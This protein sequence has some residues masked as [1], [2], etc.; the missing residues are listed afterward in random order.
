LIGLLKNQALTMGNEKIKILMIE[1]SIDDAVLIKRKLESSPTSRFQVTPVKTLQE[2]LAHLAQEQPDLILSDLG[3]PDSHGLDTVNRILKE[4]PYI[5]LVVLSGYDD[6]SVAIKAVQAGAQD[7]LVKGRIDNLQMERSLNYSIERARLQREL[8]QHN[9]EIASV[10]ANLHKVLEKNADAILVISE[11]K[12][13]LFCNPAAASLLGHTPEELLK[14]K[15]EFEIRAGVTFE[16]EIS[17]ADKQNKTAEVTAVEIDWAGKTASLVS[18]HD[19]TE[20]KKQ[21]DMLRF[22]DTALKSIH[23]GVFTMDNEFKITRWN[24]TCELM[25]G[26]K[27]SDAIGKPAADSI[28][29]VE[30]YK[31]QTE[32]RFN[33][34]IE[35]GFNREDQLYRTPRGDIWFDVQAQEMVTDGKRYGW[36]SLASDISER[37]KQEDM[38][39]FSDIA[40]KSIHEGVFTMNND[41][42]I[43]R[44]N[45]M[46]EQIVGVKAPD[47]I[48][49]DISDPIKLIEE[50]EGQNNEHVELLVKYGFV[51]SVQKYRTPH[52]DIW[53]D[54][55]TQAM[56][57]NGERF[58]WLTMLSDITARKNTEE[59][60]KQSEEKYREVINTSSD[61][62][63]SVD[64]KMKIIL[65]NQGASKIFG[66]TEKEMIGESLLTI[67]P[68]MSHQEVV[69]GF[70]KMKKTG[71]YELDDRFLNTVGIKK[72]GTSVFIELSVTTH[73]IGDSPI[74]TAII[75][76][77]TFR[78]EAEEALK[79]SEEKY[80]ELI[81]TSNDAIVSID[82]QMQ[83]VLWNRGAEKMLGYTEKEMLGL[84]LLTIFP[85]TYQKNVAR[86][87]VQLKNTG[88]SKTINKPF[89][90]YLI[91][92]D[93]SLVPVDMSISTRK[94][95]DKIISTAIIR[96]IT[97]RK[98]AEEKM[99][100]S[101]ERYRD[102]FENAS[103]LIQS[104]NA[105]GKF[106]YVNTAWREALGYSEEEVA[107][108]SLW[109]VIFPAHVAQC[110]KTLDRVLSGET[111][112]NIETAFVAKDGKII[113]VE[114][115]V[116]P[117]RKQDKVIANRAIFH[118]IN[119]RKEAEE[120]MRQ[121]DQ[122]KS[123]F[124]SNVS[125]ELRTPLQ[126]ISGFTKLI[127]NGDVPDT[128]TQQEFLQIIDQETIHLGNLINSLLDMSRLEAGRFKINRTPVKIRETI[129][130][131]LKMFQSLAR[132]KN[133]ELTEDISP[134]IPQMELDNE[135]MR[136]V[137]INLVG[138]AIKFSD[139][140]G[141]V[142]ITAE[143]RDQ[144]LFFQVIDHG[145]GIREKNIKHLFERFYREEGETVRGGT[146]LGLY[147]SKQI[148]EA[149]GGHIWAESHY[150]K[151]STFSFI[152]PLNGTIENNQGGHIY[153]QQSAD[154]RR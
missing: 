59:A 33:L 65:W 47:A 23:E 49:K 45:E 98:E 132:Q 78:K 118:N 79:R 60:L 99:R 89:E 84:S 53:V 15:Y 124:L 108:L 70:N 137:I 18:M 139:P 107:T 71:I 120:K 9:R 146:G 35:K 73:N 56:E 119:V 148:I 138:N 13:I 110:K 24:K 27:A 93:C 32:K 81:N 113:N 55:Q 116:N 46:C 64:S 94:S 102:L 96:D 134:D 20:R 144:E 44:W 50:Y 66:Y 12:K 127:L 54:V 28:N 135:R 67:V 152:L 19:I 72:D 125:H 4:A 143:Y 74:A 7:Y 100:E 123:E 34:L 85:E 154:N 95:D 10:Q 52:G 48:G 111:I 133:I 91:K 14:E 62:I 29:M 31:G 145:T 130:E 43:T 17:R 38:L 39:R 106:V 109:D 150:G 129:I 2:G 42:K 69:V 58:G 153:E 86:E 51:R 115:N 1:D 131:S 147:I 41:L 16:I 87:L 21:E 26:I 136:Q 40:L 37:K 77:V 11:D 61:A 5:P 25:F 103:D 128:E 22:S 141:S 90:T 63:I 151:G 142:K 36:I 57:H 30:E 117:V 68:S 105:S 149:H 76:D 97:V 114:G 3:L 104:C 80:R 82:P 75:R 112:N 92:K 101:E 140:G 121:I 122:M 8:E 126:S 88:I 6:E 83:F